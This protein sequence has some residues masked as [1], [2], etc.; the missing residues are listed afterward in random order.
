M[1]NILIRRRGS[2]LARVTTILTAV[3]LFWVPSVRAHVELDNPNGGEMLT[4]GSTFTI[5]WRPAVAA[6]DTLKFD[7]WYSTTADSGPWT[8]IA[9]NVPP[10]DLSVGSLH[11]FAWTVPSISDSSAWVRVRQDNNVDQDYEDVSDG[12]F[13]IAAALPGDYNGDGTVDAADYVKWRKSGGTQGQFNTWR[14]NFG[15]TAGSGRATLL[16]AVPEPA[17]TALLVIGLLGWRRFDSRRFPGPFLGQ[18]QFQHL[19]PIVRPRA[20]QMLVG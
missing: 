3:S 19:F 9:T 15:E 20:G 11:T 7:L 10:G 1:S 18:N 16:V 17:T 8:V 13:S 6:H 2:Y 4:G 12:A 14:A 5:E